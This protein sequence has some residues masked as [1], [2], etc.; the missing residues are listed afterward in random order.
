MKKLCSLVC[1]AAVALSLTV[2][3]FAQGT[4]GEVA[5]DLAQIVYDA[6]WETDTAKQ[7]VQQVQQNPD[8]YVNRLI[9][10]AAIRAVADET[11]FD[12]VPGTIGSII[13]TRIQVK[14]DNINFSAG[15][16]LGLEDYENNKKGTTT[17]LKQNSEQ[18]FTLTVDFAQEPALGSY[19]NIYVFS[20]V[21]QTGEYVGVSDKGQILESGSLYGNDL[22]SRT[23]NF[24]VP[25]SGTY[26]FTHVDALEPAPTATPDPTA[27]PVPTATPAPTSQP[28]ATPA[29]TGAPV[30]TA[31]PAP[32]GIPVPTSAPVPTATPAPGTGTPGEVVGDKADQ[33]LKNPANTQLANEIVTQINYDKTV[34]VSNKVANAMAAAIQYSPMAVSATQNGVQFAS[35]LHSDNSGFVL[36]PESAAIEGDRA[37]VSL[38]FVD[39]NGNVAQPKLGALVTVKIPGKTMPAGDYVLVGEGNRMIDS[40]TVTTVGSDTL[41]SFWAPHFSTY[42]IVPRSAYVASTGNGGNTGST[43]NNPIK[44]TGLDMSMALMGVVAMAGVAVVGGAVVAKKSKEN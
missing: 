10:N 37:Q 17:E 22:G 18:E 12:F 5:T 30:P 13:Q 9:A 24:W 29:P 2:P 26:T 11:V 33:L 16:F 15:L 19:M 40:V 14:T 44:A 20:N 23:G 1:A 28:T 7:M 34:N 25:G 27:T 36:V 4:P 42:A 38:H 3:V 32:T 6:P 43:A 31:T 35:T 41:I 39:G 8:L 21:L